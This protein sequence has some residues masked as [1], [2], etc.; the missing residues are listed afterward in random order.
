MIEPNTAGKLKFKT[1]TFRS[2]LFE[3]A[4]MVSKNPRFEDV[5][6]LQASHHKNGNADKYSMPMQI[7]SL[8]M[9]TMPINENR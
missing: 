2:S 8:F 9:Q 6:K 7:D 4:G 3:N 5:H 1:E